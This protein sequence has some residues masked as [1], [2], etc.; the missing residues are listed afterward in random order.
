MNKVIDNIKTNNADEF[1]MEFADTFGH[2]E[3]GHI[4]MREN[5]NG[6]T[7]VEFPYDDDQ[8]REVFTNLCRKHRSQDKLKT[9]K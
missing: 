4:T 7:T 5:E 9:D 2:Q 1:E 3:L 6:N 8:E